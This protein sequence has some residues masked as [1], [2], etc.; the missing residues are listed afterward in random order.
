MRSFGIILS[1]DRSSG[2]RS[3]SRFICVVAIEAADPKDR[4]DPKGSGLYLFNFVKI[5]RRPNESALPD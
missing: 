1:K 5:H 4:A 2:R 3:T